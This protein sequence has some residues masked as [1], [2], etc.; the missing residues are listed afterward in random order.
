[1]QLQVAAMFA[2]R[3]GAFTRKNPGGMTDIQAP[4]FEGRLP[5]VITIENG[6]KATLST[7]CHLEIRP[8]TR[9]FPGR[10]ARRMYAVSDNPLYRGHDRYPDGTY[11]MDVSPPIPEGAETIGLYSGVRDVVPLHP[12]CPFQKGGL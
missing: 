9:S 7:P 3:R 11:T 5:V 10:T 8:F 1:M 2:S 12:V 6:D 4:V